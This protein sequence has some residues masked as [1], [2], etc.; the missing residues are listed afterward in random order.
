MN[1]ALGKLAQYHLLQS[2]PFVRQHLPETAPY[3]KEKLSDFTSRHPVVFVK[4]DTSGQGRGV[5]KMEKRDDC[6]YSLKGYTL[7]GKKIDHVMDM[8]EIHKFL[9]PFERFGRIWPYII[10]EGIGSISVSGEPVNIRV[11]VQHFIDKTAAV[12]IYGSIAR[13]KNGISNTRRGAFAVP[14][15]QLLSHYLHIEKER[16]QGLIAEL[17][18]VSIAAARIV[19]TRH[20]SREA[21]VDLGLDKH[22]KPFI[23]EVNV[24]PGIGGFMQSDPRVWKRIIENRKKM[25][26][27]FL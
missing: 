10:Q 11:H 6:H 20:P 2:D 7:Q 14:A 24:T 1:K 17:E 19:K 13:E 26:D 3:T 22:L 18:E 27:S 12:G 5:Y 8:P 4:H 23:F 16:Q 15:Q 21:G 9:Q 25:K